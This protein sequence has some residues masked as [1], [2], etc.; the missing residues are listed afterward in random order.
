MFVLRYKAGG[1]TY[2]KEYAY[3]EVVEVHNKIAVVNLKDT[4]TFLQVCLFQLLGEISSMSELPAFLENLDKP[5]EPD[6][7]VDE[8]DIDIVPLNPELINGGGHT[9]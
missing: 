7:L 1:P 8:E 2:W 4:V 9:G 3:K 6:I 5:K